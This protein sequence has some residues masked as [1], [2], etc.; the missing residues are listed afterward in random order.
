MHNSKIDLD[1]NLENMLNNWTGH[2]R[3]KI[4]FEKLLVQDFRKIKKLLPNISIEKFENSIQFFGNDRSVMLTVLSKLK[5]V[6]VVD[7]DEQRLTLRDLL[8][9]RYVQE[10]IAW[11]M[12]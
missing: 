10:G 3:F 8:N 7:I 5:E 4:G 9:A 12:H 11:S 1:D 2:Y 6:T